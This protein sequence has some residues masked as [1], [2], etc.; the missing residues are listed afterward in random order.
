MVEGDRAI[1]VLVHGAGGGPWMWEAV[2]E[3]LDAMGVE[4]LEA[5]LPTMDENG[6]GAAD[7]HTDA[8]HVRALLDG[9]EGPL[10]LCG[11]SY[12]GIVITEA[13]AGHPRVQRLVY[14]AAAMPDVEEDVMT[15]LASACTPEFTAGVAFGPD[16]RGGID[17]AVARKVVFQQASPEVADRAIARF[18]SMAMGAGGSPTLEGA[19]WHDIPSTYVVCSED[20][21]IRPEVQRRWARSRASETIEVPFDHCSPMSHPK[22]VAEILA[23]SAEPDLSSVS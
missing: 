3:E 13:S 4:H 1:V 23:R 17:P 8:A 21:S 7:F 10:V 5:D 19:G 6:D 14:L 20:R 18:R 9:I 2:G 16:G 12:G 15:E 22:E 11:G